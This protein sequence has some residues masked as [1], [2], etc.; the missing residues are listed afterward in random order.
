MMGLSVPSLLL[1]L[2]MIHFGMQSYRLRR[3]EERWA[4]EAG[5]LRRPRVGGGVP[6][7][8]CPRVQEGRRKDKEQRRLWVNPQFAHGKAVIGARLEIITYVNYLFIHIYEYI[9]LYLEGRYTMYMHYTITCILHR[10]FWYIHSVICKIYRPLST[11]VC[12]PDHGN[13]I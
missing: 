7:Q 11:F 6:G 5:Q 9:Y 4:E 2:I 1:S 12:P 13:F 3:P 8:R 10:Y